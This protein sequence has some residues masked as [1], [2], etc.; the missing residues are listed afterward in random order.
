MA[1]DRHLKKKIW[2][3]WFKRLPT[4]GLKEFVGFT[5]PHHSPTSDGVKH[6][7]LGDGLESE[8]FFRNV[9]FDPSL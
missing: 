2:P 7:L 6:N 5:S 8:L 9:S 4:P 1:I 3:V